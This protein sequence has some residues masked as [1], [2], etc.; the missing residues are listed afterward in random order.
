[1]H[2]WPRM[3]KDRYLHRAIWQTFVDPIRSFFAR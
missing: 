1:L 3:A 2:Y